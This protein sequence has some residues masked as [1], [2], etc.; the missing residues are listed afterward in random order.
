[1]KVFDLYGISA[2]DLEEAKKAVEGVLGETLNPHESSYRCGAYYG[3]DLPHGGSITL[4]RNYDEF[5]DEWT[6]EEFKEIPFLLYVD[7]HQ[8]PDD[9]REA[10]NQRV[11]NSTF[12]K[13]DELE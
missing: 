10:M 2:A 9:V 13:R 12:L 4:Q 6:E 5:E 11:S 1:M 7:G 3:L 8:S